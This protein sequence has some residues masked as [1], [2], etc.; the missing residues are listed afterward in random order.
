MP[1]IIHQDS[2][3]NPI[4]QTAVSSGNWTNPATQASGTFPATGNTIYI[5]NGTTAL[6][7]SSHAAA[8]QL[9]QS[10]APYTPAGDDCENDAN[11]SVVSGTMATY[12]G[13]RDR[14]FVINGRNAC[15]VM[16]HESDQIGQFTFNI[17]AP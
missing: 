6:N 12:S 2:N 16:T 8:Y 11:C 1:E 7:W 5:P 10:E 3:Q 13:G 15:G 9:W 4:T 14:Y 17:P